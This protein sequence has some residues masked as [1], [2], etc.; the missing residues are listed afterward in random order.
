[1]SILKIKELVSSRRK[2]GGG[3]FEIKLQCQQIKE[4]I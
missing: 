1:M 3:D 2:R 4:T